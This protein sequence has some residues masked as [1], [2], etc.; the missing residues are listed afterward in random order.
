MTLGFVFLL[1]VMSPQLCF[2][3]CLGK[4]GAAPL[5]PVWGIHGDSLSFV[6]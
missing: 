5:E 1:E 6:S 3:F 4:G 2:Q